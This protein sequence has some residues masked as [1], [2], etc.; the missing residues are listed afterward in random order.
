MLKRILSI[1]AVAGL[2][3]VT[4]T[5]QQNPLV[6]TAVIVDEANL[7]I[8]GANF[9][10]NPSVFLSGMPLT[11]TINPLGTEI[12]ASL[13]L[14]SVAPGTYLLHVSRGNAPQHNATFSVAIGAI[15]PPGPEGPTGPTGPPGPEGP[16]GPDG[17]V[18]PMGPIGPVGPAGPAGPAGAAGAVGPA[19]PNPFA[20]LSCPAGQA[21][22]AIALT[23]PI[24]VKCAV[25]AGLQ[26]ETVAPSTLQTFTD[27]VV[28]V[29]FDATNRNLPHPTY[30][31]APTLFKAIARTCEAP[32]VYAWDFGDGT[33]SGPITTNNRYDLSASHQYPLAYTDVAYSARITLTSC[34]GVEVSA[35]NEAVYPVMHYGTIFA[36][37]PDAIRNAP[38]AN[39]DLTKTYAANGVGRQWRKRMSDKAIDDGLWRVHNDITNRAGEG[40]A[41]MT[42]NIYSSV[43][44]TGI[45]MTAMQK[46]KH[47]AAYPP[48]TYAVGDP[49]PSPAWSADNDLR[50]A[51]DPY[52]E[53]LVRMLNFLL[54]QMSAVS[55]PAADEVD[56][57]K[58]AIA[59]TNDLIGLSFVPGN[60]DAYHTG[61]AAGAL[62]TSGMAGTAAQ[63]G[64][65]P[66]VRGQSIQ[67][68]AQQ[69][70]DYMVWFQNDGG[71]YPGGFYYS[72]NV[73][74]QDASTSQWM[75]YGL[76]AMETALAGHGV[77]VNDRYKSRVA[78]LI[79]NTM[80]AVAGP[81]PSRPYGSGGHSY[82]PGLAGYAFQLSAG[83]L[84]A[85][86]MMG[87]HNP[88]W[89]NTNGLLPYDLNAGVITRGQAYVSFRKQFD[90]IGD[91]WHG[92]GGNDGNNW[93]QGQWSGGATGYLLENN[94]YNLYSMLWAA[95]GLTAVGAVCVGGTEAV[96]ADGVCTDGNDWKHQH[97]VLLVRRQVLGPG[98][99][100]WVSMRGN[101]MMGSIQQQM[102]TAMA[103]INLTLAQ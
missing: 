17:P 34:N 72:P 89:E 88:A 101:P 78:G 77:I 75:Y 93:G 31:G 39:I 83:P 64:Q 30:N 14:P 59:G 25:V 21:V 41:T 32:I 46:R 26:F 35:N 56:D 19:G 86:G 100:L 81:G 27:R 13:P 80:H 60:S 62:A 58:A 1:A 24:Q 47:R 99:A 50:Y 95:N 63:V 91:D 9:G 51:S 12:T 71:S 61:I 55:V 69:A 3:T 29:P 54:S 74:S 20:T 103:V 18:G 37:Q 84:V 57:G 52:A 33:S 82:N 5:A 102:K 76:H 98:G 2:L 11:R 49:T 10:A 73:F 53:D 36:D 90:Y 79:R 85:M 42:A 45:A 94:D 4:T 40:T 97:T 22:V 87:W 6:I 28:T 8:S 65:I 44:Y 7:Y 92:T 48:G 43:A 96:D 23:D 38:A 15:G 66:Y 70:V 16:P 67:F 68:I